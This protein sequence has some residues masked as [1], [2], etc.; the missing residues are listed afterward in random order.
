MFS[1][2]SIVFAW[3]NQLRYALAL[4]EDLTDEQMVLRP[5]GNMNHPAWI[6]GHVGLYHPAVVQLLAGAPVDD[7]KDDP[8]FGYQ[9]H[10]PL[11]DLS[12][13]GDKRT[14]IARFSDGHEKVAQALLAAAPEQFVQRPSLQR[15]A[16][17]YPT[18]E[19]MLPDLLLHH[20][21]LHLGQLSIWRRAA[22]LPR[23]GSTDRTP[24]EGLVARRRAQLIA[25]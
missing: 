12:K 23:I 6:L 9:G 10:G 11:G 2:E 22:G 24:R 21:S 25:S 17:V 4:L 1:A 13:Y 19:F 5:G 14:M 7:P 3:D 18:V 16:N 20:E 15:W 8:L